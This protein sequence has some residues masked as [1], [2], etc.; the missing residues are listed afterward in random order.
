LMAARRDSDVTHR[1]T[2]SPVAGATSRV[3][4]QALEKSRAAS[5][6]SADPAQL[7][8]RDRRGPYV[9]HQQL[10]AQPTTPSG[11]RMLGFGG[12]AAA[13]A[14]AIVAAG[15]SSSQNQA[16]SHSTQSTAHKGPRCGH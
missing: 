2:W 5:L 11:S 9:A 4:A 8:H 6:S 7:V 13:A 3:P 15:C 10:S 16:T 14:L 12:L 1:T